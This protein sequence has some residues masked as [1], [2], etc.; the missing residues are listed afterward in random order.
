MPVITI[1]GQEY[2]SDSFSEEA[3][4]QLASLQI[5]DRKIADLNNDLKILHTARNAYAKALSGI[6]PPKCP[7]MAV[8]GAGRSLCCSASE[9]FYHQSGVNMFKKIEPLTPSKHQD[10]RFDQQADF[11]FAEQVFCRDD[12]C[13]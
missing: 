3:K 7:I 2:D 12:F 13:F 5:V 4:A 6:L 11:R 1:D 10:L 8:P 9:L